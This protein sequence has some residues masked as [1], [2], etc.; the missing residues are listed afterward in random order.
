MNEVFHEGYVTCMKWKEHFNGILFQESGPAKK[1]HSDQRTFLVL[2][3]CVLNSRV[4][5]GA[6]IYVSFFYPKDVPFTSTRS[7]SLRDGRERILI[8]G[9]YS[10]TSYVSRLWR[11]PL[12]PARICRYGFSLKWGRRN[13]FKY[14]I[15]KFKTAIRRFRV[16]KVC[17]YLI[18]RGGL[19]EIFAGLTIV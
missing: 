13:I 10:V 7:S 14:L 8:L 3:N 5:L 15:T 18:N 9:F 11:W 2:L 4:V 17:I 16:V 1:Q 6:H 19:S 12:S